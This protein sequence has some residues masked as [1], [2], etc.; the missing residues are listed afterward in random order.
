MNKEVFVITPIGKKGSPTYAKFDAIFTTMIEPA[1]KSVD[2]DFSVKRADRVAK[3]GSFVKD[4]LNN[5]RNAFIVIANLTDLNANVFYELGVR[6]TLSNRTIIITE[7]LSSLPSDLQEYRAI[8]YKPDITAVEDFKRNLSNAIKEILADP[9]HPDNPV[10]DRIGSVISSREKEYVDEI[11]KLRRQLVGTR[12]PTA[13]ATPQKEKLQRRIDRIFNL[14]NAEEGD[15]PAQAWN[16]YDSK[17][18]ERKYQIP[19]PQ[20]NFRYYFL[21]DETQEEYCLVIAIH[22]SNFDLSIDFADIRVMVSQYSTIGNARFRFVV[23]AE[24]DLSSH[25]RKA[26]TFL[27]KCLDL[28]KVK[29]RERFSLELWD[30]KRLIAIEKQEGLRT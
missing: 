20:G 3:P 27:N 24:F 4:I 2:S 29:K 10:Q 14:W 7:D 6:H 8:E 1:A 13:S 15:E 25:K 22:D 18:K 28:T 11:G 19:A 5:L 17:G 26:A 30:K 23:V 16:D 21:K 9:E 12:T